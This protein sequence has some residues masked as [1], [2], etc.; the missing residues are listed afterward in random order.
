MRLPFI[1][2]FAAPGMFQSRMAADRR[3]SR[4][5]VDT[6]VLALGASVFFAIAC[7]G[8]LFDALLAQRSWAATGS[9]FFAACMLLLLIGM[10]T[11][12]LCLVL[13][14]WF[15]RPLLAVLIVATAFATYFMQR[16]GVIFDPTMMRNVLRTDPAEAAELMG[17]ALLPH[18][19]T[20]GGLPL[21][22]L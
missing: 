4:P 18:L 1:D 5:A 19:A 9:W 6:E 20:H 22:L 21:A 7:N 17:W 11:F 14:R 13:H 12:L 15:A 16:L 10:N 8:P 3:L 2:G